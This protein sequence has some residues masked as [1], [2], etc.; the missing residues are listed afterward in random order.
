MKAKNVVYLLLFLLWV[1]LAFQVVPEAAAEG[2]GATVD[3]PATHQKGRAPASKFYDKNELPTHDP[4]DAPG[5]G[6]TW[7]LPIREVELKGDKLRDLGGVFCP[8]LK[9]RKNGGWDHRYHGI[10]RG[11]DLGV[12]R[13]ELGGRK[14]PV[15]VIA[16]GVYDG[17]R[18]YTHATPLPKDCKPL[19]VYHSS[20]QDED[21]QY[22]SIYCH[23]DPDPNLKVDQ[24]LKGGQVIGTLEDPEGSWGAHVHLE[25][26]TRRVYSSKDSTK[27]GRCGC[28]NNSDCD[29][30]TR[31]GGKIP[32]GCGIFEDDL[33]IMDPVLFIRNKE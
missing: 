23:V 3:K 21:A 8:T 31:A 1:S 9:G 22:T 24:K 15:H 20:A 6:L 16:D 32:R 30:K 17:Q 7:Q 12:W 27:Y 10:H 19:V 26:Y 14:I 13:K 11:H 29:Q 2:A 28:K 4:A 33:Y 18:T 25:L 5:L